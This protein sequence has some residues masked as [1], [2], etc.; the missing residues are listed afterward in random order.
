[1]HRYFDCW[2]QTSGGNGYLSLKDFDI[3]IIVVSFTSSVVAKQ[4]FKLC[5]QI[6]A[7]GLFEFIYILPEKMQACEEAGIFSLCLV[8]QSLWLDEGK[9]NQKKNRPSGQRNVSVNKKKKSATNLEKECPNKAPH[10]TS[11]YKLLVLFWE[12]LP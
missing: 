5:N 1:M 9:S 2:L 7:A 4:S 12:K 6:K 3:T 10:G 8:L 11:S